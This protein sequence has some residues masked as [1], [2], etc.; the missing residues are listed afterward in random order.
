MQHF[1]F[2]STFRLNIK[3][4]QAINKAGDTDFAF[5]SATL[6]RM[7]VTF[8]S[9]QLR[10]KWSNHIWQ[11]WFLPLTRRP[12]KNVSTEDPRL[13]YILRN[14]CMNMVV[15]FIF[16]FIEDGCN[17]HNLSIRLRSYCP[18]RV[19]WLQYI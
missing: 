5:M 10:P 7:H 12:H 6:S 14:L 15:I 16:C 18:F 17:L 8:N 9:I 13:E 2:L 1:F 19:R 11:E 4:I 3:I